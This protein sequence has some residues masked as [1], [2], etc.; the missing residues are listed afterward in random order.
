[1][2]RAILLL[3]LLWPVV[4]FADYQA[5]FEAAAR[6]DYATA[7]RE[8]RPLAEQGDARAQYGLGIMYDK[9]RGVTQDHA[10]ALKWIRLAAEQAGEVATFSPRSLI[11]LTYALCGFVHLASMGIFV[12]GLAAL[13]P[14]RAAEL[15]ILGLRALW[16]AFLESSHLPIRFAQL[17]VGGRASVGHGLRRPERA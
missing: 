9:G 8:L 4:G 17:S 7:L 2:K 3:A 10:E 5:G 16:T 14:E 6:G 13:V 15:S 11:V 1:M 12:G